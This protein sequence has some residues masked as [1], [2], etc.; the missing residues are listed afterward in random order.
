MLGLGKDIIPRLLHIINNDLVTPLKFRPNCG[1]L[2]SNLSSKRKFFSNR[3]LYLYLDKPVGTK[4]KTDAKSDTLDEGEKL[5]IVCEAHSRPAPVYELYHHSESGVKK[6]VKK[7]KIS[8]TGEF[9]IENIK[10]SERGNYSCFPR[11]DEGY[12]TSASVRVYVRCE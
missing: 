3:E 2:D 7:I 5:K 6:E 8:K 10:P 12:G 4:M 1:N 11:N 9:Y